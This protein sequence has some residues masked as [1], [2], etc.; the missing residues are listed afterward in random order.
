MAEAMPPHLRVAVPIA[1]WCSLRLGEVLGLQRGDFAN[2]DDPERA[3]IH[4]QR[5]WNSKATPPGYTDPK[6][7]SNRH[8][9]IPP[10]LVQAVVEHLEEYTPPGDR[11]PFLPST[12]NPKMPV[13]Q[14]AFDVAWRKAREAVRPGFRFHS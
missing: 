12:Q 13:S 4:I 11:A 9:A 5:Q 3:T 14:T 10:S 6:A 1:A 7:G 8:I 2:L